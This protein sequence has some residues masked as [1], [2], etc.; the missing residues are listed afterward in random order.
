MN[1]LSGVD[2]VCEKPQREKKHLD[3]K[4]LEQNSE[5]EL[6]RITKRTSRK[7]ESILESQTEPADIPFLEEAFPVLKGKKELSTRRTKTGKVTKPEVSAAVGKPCS[8]KTKNVK[9]LDTET[10]SFD[11]AQFVTEYEQYKRF[12]A[13]RRRLEQTTLT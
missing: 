5:K 6:R 2:P 7:K 8:S 3:K 13:V 9:D 4:I 12:L 1:V 11:F 10:V